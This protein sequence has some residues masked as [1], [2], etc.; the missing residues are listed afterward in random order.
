MPKHK[1]FPWL[2]RCWLF[3]VSLLECVRVWHQ[4]TD[5]RYTALRATSK[6]FTDV[7]IA[8]TL[9][10]T[11]LSM[12]MD[13]FFWFRIFSKILGE[14]SDSNRIS[15]QILLLCISLSWLWWKRFRESFVVYFGLGEVEG[16]IHPS[17]YKWWIGCV[18]VACRRRRRHH[19]HHHNHHHRR[20]QHY[21]WLIVVV[22]IWNCFNWI[23]SQNAINANV[24]GSGC[25]PNQKNNWL[26]RERNAEDCP[27]APHPFDWILSIRFQF[28]SQNLCLSF[29]WF[30]C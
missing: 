26:S 13:D 12:K 24:C 22:P 29:L 3:S 20:R 8:Y 5:N 1:Y 15:I 21:L 23:C 4:H 11:I 9:T 14:F 18:W 6:R 28:T 17:P 19:H 30:F 7:C 25:W 27:K 2:H 10:T 16:S